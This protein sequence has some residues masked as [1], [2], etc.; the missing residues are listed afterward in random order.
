MEV[1]SSCRGCI[2]SFQAAIST[3]KDRGNDKERHLIDKTRDELERFSLWAGNIGALNAPTSPLSL[4]SR[5]RDVQDILDHIVELLDDLHEAA[6][7]RMSA[8]MC[9]AQI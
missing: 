2:A 4:E 7:D 1:R 3:L 9:H 8:K 5:L 6:S